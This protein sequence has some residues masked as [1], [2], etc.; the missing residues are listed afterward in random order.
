[1]LLMFPSYQSTF[2]ESMDGALGKAGDALQ[3]MQKAETSD[4]TARN[5]MLCKRCYMR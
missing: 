1:M 5:W 2:L 3:E 4:A